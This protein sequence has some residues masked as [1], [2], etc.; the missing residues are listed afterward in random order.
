MLPFKKILTAES[1]V[2]DLHTH[3]QNLLLRQKE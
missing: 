3:A 2:E 1:E